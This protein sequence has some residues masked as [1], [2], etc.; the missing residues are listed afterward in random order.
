MLI[1]ELKDQI[2]QIKFFSH[3]LKVIIKCFQIRCHLKIEDNEICFISSG[4]SPLISPSHFLTLVKK[5]TEKLV[6]V[7]GSFQVCSQT[8]VEFCPFVEAWWMMKMQLYKWSFTLNGNQL[9]QEFLKTQQFV[10]E[11]LMNKSFQLWFL[12]KVSPFCIEILHCIFKPVV[13]YFFQTRFPAFKIPSLKLF[14]T[15]RIFHKFEEC[16]P[17]DLWQSV[18][19]DDDSSLKIKRNGWKTKWNKW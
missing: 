1:K 8:F 11:N 17:D 3:L 19:Q 5:S 14:W 16:L 10:E 12:T 4:E 15:S 6:Q 9:N 2:K 18:L 7:M 13:H